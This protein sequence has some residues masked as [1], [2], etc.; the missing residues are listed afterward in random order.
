MKRA[1]V[2][3]IHTNKIF[4]Q[5]LTARSKVARNFIQHTT[6]NLLK[7]PKVKQDTTEKMQVRQPG[8]KLWGNPK[9]QKGIKMQ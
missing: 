3:A 5:N 9:L 1:I 4:K 2:S 8:Q 6:K 7:K